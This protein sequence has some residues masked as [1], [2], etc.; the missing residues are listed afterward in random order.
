MSNSSGSERAYQGNDGSYIDDLMLSV[1]VPLTEIEQNV[2]NMYLS[3]SSDEA[4][5]ADIATNGD[6]SWLM[7]VA[8]T[9]GQVAAKLFPAEA[10]NTPVPNN[11]SAKMPTIANPMF[12]ICLKLMDKA[13]ELDR[14]ADR[15]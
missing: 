1:L 7:V 2:L 15:P 5:V 14:D 8:F 10:T 11:P 3:A 4:L 9:L 6:A 12:D 13:Q